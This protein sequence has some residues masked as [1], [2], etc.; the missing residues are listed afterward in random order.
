MVVSAVVQGRR[1]AQVDWWR[2]FKKCHFG[3]GKVLNSEERE[4]AGN[5]VK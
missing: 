2:R 3:Q 4:A 1:Q 5:L